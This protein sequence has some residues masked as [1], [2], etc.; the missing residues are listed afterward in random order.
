MNLFYCKIK[1]TNLQVQKKL[2]IVQKELKKLKRQE[3]E[4]NDAARKEATHETQDVNTNNTNLLNTISIPVS[5]VGPSRAFNNDEPSYLDDPLIPHLEDIYASPSAEIFTNSSYDDEGVVTDFN[6]LETTMNVSP[7]PTTGIHT[8]CPKTQILRYPILAVQSRSKV[9]KNSEAHALWNPK[10]S[11]KHWKM[12]VRLMLCKMN[13]CSSNSEVRNKARLV[14]Q[15]HREEE[16]IDYDEVFAPMVKIEAIRIFLAFASYMGFIVYQ[17]DVKSAFL[18]GTI[19]EEVYVTQPPGFVDPKFPNKV[20]QKEDGI[21]ISQD[22]YVAEILKK[23]DFL[24]VKTA[25]TPIEAQKPLVKDEEAADIDVY[26]YSA[27]VLKPP[28]GM[29]LA[30][31]WHQ[32]SSVLPQTRSLTSPE[33]V[34][35]MQDIDEEEPAKVE[36]VL[37]VVKAAKLM[38]EV[39]TT[40]QPTTTAAQVSKASAP[41]RRRGVVIQDLEETTT[42]VIMHSEVQ[43]KNKEAELNA[44]I[45]WNDV[46]EQV[47]RNEKQDNAVMRYQALKR[48]HVTEAQARKNMMIHLKNLASFKMDFF[49][50]MTYSEIRPIFKKL[51]NLIQ[52]FLEKVKD[53]VTVQEEGNKRQDESLEQEIAKKQRMD[54]EAEELKRH[55]QIVANDDDDVHTKATPLASKV[56][57]VDY[58]IH[59]ENNKPYYKIIR[60]D[61]T[62]RL[63][64]SFITLLKNFDR[65]DLEALWKLVKERFETIKPKNFSDDFLINTLKIM[66]EKPNVEMLLLVEKK[67]PLAYFTLQQMLDNVRLE[68]EKESEM[69]LELPRLKKAQEKDKVGLKPKKREA[70]QS[71]EKFEAVTVDRGRKTEENK[72]RMNKNA[73]TSQKL[74]KFKEKKKRKWLVLQIQERLSRRTIFVTVLKLYQPRTVHEID[75]YEMEGTVEDK[76]LVSKPP[77]N[78]ARRTRCGYLVDGPNCQGCALVRQELKENLVTHS[79]DFQNSSEPSNASTN[80][81]NAPQESYVVKQD[82][83]SFL[84]KIIFRAPDSPDQFHCFHCKD[85]LRPGEACK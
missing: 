82:N 52:A 39:V 83:R 31:L 68:V 49:K 6:N 72:K 4:A 85:V 57:V 18:Y 13:C 9:Y 11:L 44:N 42:S 77:K 28:I 43:S 79:P 7:T 46:I 55:L 17:I 65:E 21:F 50:G 26:L 45:N 71:R 29:N 75:I 23:F 27:L 78:C 33:K 73:N 48:K 35:S 37:E 54:E 41:R 40:A 19:N 80:I 67:Y 10:R 12:K 53:E 62:H 76:I 8:I 60:A 64:L 22:K 32:Q 3:K 5:A 58:Q 63:F 16:G 25:S 56:P 61:G 34:L 70:W 69:S 74:L 15:G 84:D 2:T 81:V 1:L 30:A 59:Y 24:S 20:K 14:A 36:E 47:K 66:F 38:T 51:Y